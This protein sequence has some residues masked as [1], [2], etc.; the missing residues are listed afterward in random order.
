VII[1][2]PFPRL[3]TPRLALRAFRFEDAPEVQRLAGDRELAE[4]TL[5]PHP[6][7]DGM[8]EAWI[9]RQ[10]ADFDA[11][12]AINFAIERTADRALLGSIGLELAAQHAKLGCWIGRPYWGQEYGT[13]ATRAVVGYGF[14]VLGLERIWAPRFRWNKRSARVLEKLGFVHEGCR[15]EHIPAR[16]RNEIVELHG[17]LRWE[18]DAQRAARAAGESE[19]QHAA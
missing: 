19:L 8:A 18:W 2:R 9:A 11:V 6:Y 3:G 14:D 13:E 12:H 4:G 5:L 1:N 10:A 17:M 15:R 16:G 7:A